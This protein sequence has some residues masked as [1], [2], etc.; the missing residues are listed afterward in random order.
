[1]YWALT[2]FLVAEEG[3]DQRLGLLTQKRF[4]GDVIK[5]KD[6]K[7]PDTLGV[8]GQMSLLPG[9]VFFDVHLDV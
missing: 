4:L 5:V 7:I 2:G 1:L 8:F 3:I 6:M 9:E